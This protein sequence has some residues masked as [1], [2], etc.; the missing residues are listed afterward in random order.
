MTWGTFA[1]K[2]KPFGV[3]LFQPSTVDSGRH[4]IEGVV[5]FDGVKLRGVVGE[6]V[7]RLHALRDRSY[8]ASRLR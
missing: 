8:R 6:E 2:M 7:G 1:A 3:L 5:E 4:A